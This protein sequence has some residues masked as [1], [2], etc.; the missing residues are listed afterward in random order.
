[1]VDFTNDVSFSAHE[2]KKV[3]SRCITK[4][5]SI[6]A[7]QQRV[8]LR[9][10]RELETRKWRANRALLILVINNWKFFS[11][12][13][14][15][16]DQKLPFFISVEARTSRYQIFTA[17]VGKHRL[18]MRGCKHFSDVASIALSWL[19]K[20]TA[21]AWRH[22]T[23]FLK[24]SQPRNIDST[25]AYPL[26]LD[27]SYAGELFSKPDTVSLAENRKRGDA[28]RSMPV[29]RIIWVTQGQLQV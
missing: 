3:S 8:M 22:S 16:P 14:N 20:F 24:D 9:L 23:D 1:M 17:D 25:P 4:S 15:P 18:R 10:F 5:G 21:F 7:R 19:W 6:V 27:S 28:C 26:C 13:R 11:S 12:G 29:S 2:R